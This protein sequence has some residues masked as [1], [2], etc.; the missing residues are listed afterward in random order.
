MPFLSPILQR[1]AVLIVWNH[2][3]E[4]ITKRF[5]KLEQ[6]LKFPCHNEILETE[7]FC[8]KLLNIYVRNQ[9][10]QCPDFMSV[11]NGE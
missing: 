1:L 11:A 6:L 8:N 4:N 5:V 10:R 3:S 7:D 9:P 2:R